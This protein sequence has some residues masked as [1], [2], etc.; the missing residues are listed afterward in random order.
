VKG[1]WQLAGDQLRVTWFK[2]AGAVP[3]TGLRT[4]TKR[5][6]TILDREL[7]LEVAAA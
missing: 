6:A 1:T 7:R 4:E 2:E 5:L 3:R